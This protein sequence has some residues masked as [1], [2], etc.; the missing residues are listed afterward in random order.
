MGRGVKSDARWALLRSSCHAVESLAIPV[1]FSTSSAAAAPATEAWPVVAAAAAAATVAALETAVA[2]AA[3]AATV[4]ALE[5]AVAAIA[6]TIF[7]FAYGGCNARAA[8]S[9]ATAL[10]PWLARP[11]LWRRR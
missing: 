10:N 6:E 7:D 1:A 8:E 4:A 5:T 9:M 3:A 2:A 11:Q